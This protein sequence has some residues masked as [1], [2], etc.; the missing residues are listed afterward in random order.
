MLWGITDEALVAVGVAIAVDVP[1]VVL[2]VRKA[3]SAPHT[4]TMA[5]WVMDGGAALVAAIMLGRA[6]VASLAPELLLGALRSSVG[7]AG[8]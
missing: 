1:A 5:T 3:A 8:S 4:E 7:L 2:T 6:A